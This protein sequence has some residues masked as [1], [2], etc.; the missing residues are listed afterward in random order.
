MKQYAVDLGGSGIRSNAVNADR[1]RTGLFG[2]GLLSKRAKARGVS[3]AEYLGG[4]LI[5]EEVYA[6]DVAQAFLHLAKARKTTGAT[7]TVDG[8]NAAAFPR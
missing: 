6:E 5:G 2:G 3:V 8:G 1:V 4:N 7:L